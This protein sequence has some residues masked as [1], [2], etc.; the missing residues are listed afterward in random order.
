VGKKSRAAR[1]NEAKGR[2]GSGDSVSGSRWFTTHAYVRF[3]E[4]G[5]PD[6]RCIATLPPEVLVDVLAG[7]WQLDLAANDP[8]IAC[9]DVERRS[10]EIWA[11]TRAEATSN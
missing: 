5:V 8:S 9:G 7:F 3:R 4:N 11:D 6:A 2:G 1:N 10:S